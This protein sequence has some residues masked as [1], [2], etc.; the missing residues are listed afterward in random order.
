M[1]GEAIFLRSILET[2][3]RSLA[4][5][6]LHSK[7]YFSD[8]EDLRGTCEKYVH[9]F[10]RRTFAR[11]NSPK[12]VVL[13]H[14]QL[15]PLFPQ[16]HELVPEAKFVIIVRD[17]R[18]TVASAVTA[19]ARGAN[20]FEDDMPQEIASTLFDYYAACLSCQSQGFR[21]NTIYVRYEGFL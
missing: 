7:Y 6:D 18:D 19:Q 15:T 21:H 9:D 3:W 8:R 4:M 1:I 5:F 2:Y 14:P 13:K 20:E 17:P 16:L 10:V 11:Y 12:H